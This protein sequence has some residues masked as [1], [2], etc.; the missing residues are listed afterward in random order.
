M[1]AALQSNVN[2]NIASQYLP[3]TKIRTDGGTQSRAQLNEEAIADY[4][5]AMSEG[6]S[7]PPVL[8]FYDGQDYW[9]ADGF[10]RIHA[11]CKAELTQLAVEVRQGSRREAVLYS[12]G[13]NANHGLRRTNADKQ[14]AAETLLRDEEWRQW[15]DNAIAKACGVSQPF[16]GKLRAKLFPTYNGYKSERKSLDG[17]TL[18]TANIGIGNSTNT[19]QRS[20][21]ASSA[22]AAP[23][24]R[25]REETDFTSNNSDD[26]LKSDEL[27]SPATVE[28]SQTENHS[29]STAETTLLPQDL[30][31]E[32]KSKDKQLLPDLPPNADIPPYEVSLTPAAFINTAAIASGKPDIVAVEISIGMKSLTPNQLA[33]ALNNAASYGLSDAHL[34]AVIKTAKQALNARHHA[35]YF[36]HQSKTAC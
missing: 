20:S 31:K 4:A 24:T 30:V 3:I 15:S 34:K 16:V 7:F 29:H 21:P 26:L 11:A 18:N 1:V 36:Q 28:I 19:N 33:W 25:N 17:R 23:E 6:A 8:V 14:R 9:L 35:E 12:V 10:H 13:A 2:S 32:P 22:I 27:P 5:E